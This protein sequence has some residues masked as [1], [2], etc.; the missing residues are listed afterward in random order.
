MN[1]Y[2]TDCNQDTAYLLWLEKY[3]QEKVWLIIFFKLIY[4]V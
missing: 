2:G 3:Y 1:V 4:E